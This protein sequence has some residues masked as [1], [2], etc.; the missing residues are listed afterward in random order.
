MPTFARNADSGLPGKNAYHILIIGV[1]HLQR[2]LIEFVAYY[3]LS[4][5]HQGIDQRTPFQP[6]HMICEGSI[7]KKKM[8]GGIINDYYRAP[9][10][11]ALAIS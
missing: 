6:K 3:N 11:T 7:Q 5:L 4:H 8:L 2:V 1:A 9:T 10:N